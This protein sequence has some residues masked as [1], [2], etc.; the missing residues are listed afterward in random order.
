MERLAKFGARSR[1]LWGVFSRVRGG[2]RRKICGG[3][4]MELTDE[5]IYGFCQE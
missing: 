5:G 3:V 2:F 4:F 1:P